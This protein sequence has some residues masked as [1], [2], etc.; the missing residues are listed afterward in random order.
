MLTNIGK[1]FQLKYPSQ[2][3]VEIWFLKRN[4]LS[5]RKIA[6]QRDVTPAFV[7]KTLKE[8]NKRI[9]SLLKSTAKANKITPEIISPEL[10]FIKG[11]SHMFNCTAYITFS[12]QNSIQVWYD[13]KGN[14]ATCEDFSLCKQFYFRSLKSEILRLITLIYNQLI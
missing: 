12:P 13:H 11:K 10:G 7:S 9:E 2:A 6:Q 4:N 5:G 1:Y 3:Q 14:C 8:A